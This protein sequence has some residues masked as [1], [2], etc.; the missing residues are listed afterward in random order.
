ML[1]KPGIY[2][3]GFE[4]TTDSTKKIFIKTKSIQ[5]IPDALRS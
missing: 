3:F 5:I 1:T 4:K 2:A